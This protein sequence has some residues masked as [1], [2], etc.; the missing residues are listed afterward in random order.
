[1]AD[2]FKYRID[3][4]GSLIRPA[5][6]L[7]ARARHA[8]GELDAAGLRAAED[9]AIAEAVRFQRKLRLSVVT[10]GD[11]RRA[12]FRGAILETVHGF[13]RTEEADKYGRPTWLASA[14]LKADGPLVAADVAALAELTGA[15]A[16]KATLPSPAYL[17]ATSFDPAGPYKTPA[18]LGEALARVVRAEIEELIA[19]GV[20]LIQ[21][22]NFRYQAYL[23]G[24]GGQPLTL[25]EAIA[26]DALAVSVEDRPEGVR[27]GLCPTHKAAD[28]DHEAAARLFAE[29]PVDRWIL[30][31]DQGTQGETDLLK[32]VPADRDAAL[33]IVS[34]RASALE[35]IDTIMNRMDVAAEL[36]DIEDIAI[37]PSSGFSDTAGAPEIS[38]E[39]QRRKLVHVET[40]AR[41]CWGNE[42]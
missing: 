39:D 3:H 24:R 23:F 15:A 34:P 20:R 30:P 40:I 22:N 17:A 5:E 21:L 25:E 1:M 6:V 38:A 36:K 12:D 4:H 32:A 33:G 11:F 19:R 29:L 9:A 26:I 10:D 27:I 41:M 31:Y 13:R 18:E 16:P 35:D 7:A 14:E 28:V 8:A 2:T 42:L 37:T